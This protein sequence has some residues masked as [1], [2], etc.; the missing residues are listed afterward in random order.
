MYA[1]LQKINKKLEA[2]YG[3]LQRSKNENLYESQPADKLSRYLFAKIHSYNVVHVWSETGAYSSGGAGFVLQK[4]LELYRLKVI[5]SIGVAFGMSLL[6]QRLCD[7]IIS[8]TVY[9]YDKGIKVTKEGITQKGEQLVRTSP[10]IS[11]KMKQ[12]RDLYVNNKYNVHKGDIL[13]G[14]AVVSDTS[15]KEKITE[16]FYSRK[17]V[18]GEMEGYG[19]YMQAQIKKIPCVV[20]KG[21]CDWGMQKMI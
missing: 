5:F 10:W 20:I 13:S 8:Q 12:R 18:G 14:E 16:L 3:N 21:L 1:N 15:Y 19:I 9:A 17:F 4:I 7:T 6:E 2:S 11:D